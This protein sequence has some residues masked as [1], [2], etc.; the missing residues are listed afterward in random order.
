MGLPSGVVQRLIR[1]AFRL[2]LV[3]VLLCSIDACAGRHGTSTPTARHRGVRRAMTVDKPSNGVHWRP[4]PGTSWQWQLNDDIDLDVDAEVYDVDG[5]DVSAATVAKL[6]ARGRKVICYLDIGAVERYRPDAHEFP[7][8]VVGREVDG[9]PDERYLDIRRIDVVGPVLRRRLEMCR[10]KGFDGVEG[11]L[12]DAY[13]NPSGFAI[14]SDD[15]VRFIRWFATEAH[16]LGLAAGLKNVPDLVGQLVD[17]VDFAVVE[18]CFHEGTCAA[19]RPFIDREK[20]VFDAEYLAS[21]DRFCAPT[22]AAGISAIAKRLSLG[23]WRDV[24]DVHAP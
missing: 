6:H 19:Y 13:A 11:D 15:E 8:H 21:P 17:D 16:R 9:W 20:A 2:A 4:K 22:R 10:D 14:S 23:A 5:F 24:C 18:D 7:A 12:V 3:V 1:R